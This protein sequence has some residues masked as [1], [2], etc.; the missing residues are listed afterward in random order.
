MFGFCS[1]TKKAPARPARRPSLESLEARDCPSTFAATLLLPVDLYGAYASQQSN[2][3]AGPLVVKE[4]HTYGSS[5]NVNVSGSVSGPGAGGSLIEFEGPI[6]GV[7]TANAD[8]TFSFTAPASYLGNLMVGAVNGG[9]VS[10]NVLQD[11]IADV[12]PTIVNFTCTKLN[13]TTYQFTAQVNYQAPAAGLMVSFGGG[14]LML[15]NEAATVQTNGDL[16]T[17]TL[18]VDST[19]GAADTGTA[20]AQVVSD[21]WGLSSNVASVDVW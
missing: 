19:N 7:T 3:A 2:G 5:H 16:Y 17:V 8:G 20:T 13:S 6:D 18:T 15:Q 4:S 10:S 21:W 12:A 11:A 14:P 9:R 1:P